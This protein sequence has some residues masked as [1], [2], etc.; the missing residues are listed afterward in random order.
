MQKTNSLV[1]K[2][3]YP[4]WLRG[5]LTALLSLLMVGVTLNLNQRYSELPISSGR[6]PPSLLAYILFSLAGC[7]FF[8]VQ[9]W[10]G[11]VFAPLN[12]LRD[13]LGWVR[14]IGVLILGLAPSLF[15][16]DTEWTNVFSGFWV[17]LWLELV[18]L[19]LMVW[20][21]AVGDQ[22]NWDW[23]G[24][25]ASLILFASLAEICGY[26]NN[27][28]DYPFS[29][30]PAWSEGNRLWDYSVLFGKRLYIYPAD[31]AIPAYTDIGRQSLWGLPFLFM[32]PSILQM[33]IWDNLVWIVPNILLG[34]AL[35]KPLKGQRWAWFLF[36]FWALIFLIQGPVYSPLIL[37]AVLVALARRQPIWLAV[38][39]VM[40]AGLYARYTRYTWMFAPAIWAGMVW[41][42]QASVKTDKPLWKSWLPAF[43]V[44]LG[45]LLG[46][47]LIPE[48][49]NLISR[50]LYG[51]P[52][53]PGVAN[54][55]EI[56]VS[57]LSQTV[58]RQPLL[59][60][61]LWPNETYS[62]GIVPGILF[63]A[64]PLV[65]LLALLAWKGGW[66]LTWWQ[67]LAIWGPLAAFLGVGL[68]VSVK[69][70]GGSN[71]HNLDM[72]LIALLFLFAFAWEFMTARWGANPGAYP[73]WVKSI[74]VLMICLPMTQTFTS[75]SNV[76]YPDE[77]KWKDALGGV[78]DASQAAAQEGEVLFIDQRQLLTFG[79]VKGVPLVAD[80][81][82]KYLM[83]QAMADNETYFEPFIKDLA[84]HRFKLI[85]SEPL[86]V[87]YQGDHYTF[88]NENDQWVKW[89]SIPVL[90]YYQVETKYEGI[91]EILKPREK[92]ESP[93][94]GVEC[95]TPK[96]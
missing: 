40:V 3:E 74:M 66:S 39:L 22:K 33:R 67:K 56:T 36:G 68:V 69:I 10:G 4:L 50:R 89:V 87:H 23:S 77:V 12:R 14:W 19:G 63:A 93:A 95:P 64:G 9:V 46:G 94:P 8:M 18:F 53:Q 70:G 55:T 82:K 13:R 90:C 30:K 75:L 37:A 58:N 76:G 59:W 81:E 51:G 85:I 62:L 52:F 16:A 32:N 21:A 29:I 86:Y 84:N 31:K 34:W 72:F 96:P 71:L 44:T 45:G 48:L 6:F 41:M 79:E 27:I 20:L 43:W 91:T 88:G 54:V 73:W 7:L 5:S 49:L 38:L 80:Y 60:D 35:V 83:D 11:S 47:Y 78:R 24:L 15:L 42:L 57:S 1:F 92:A 25:M 61:R 26:F 2:S 17:R 28:T 65:L